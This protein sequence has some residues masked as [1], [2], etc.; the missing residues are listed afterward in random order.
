MYLKMEENMVNVHVKRAHIRLKCT[1]HVHVNTQLG[2]EK[3]RN[4]IHAGPLM[5]TLVRELVQYPIITE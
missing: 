1:L 4:W 2:R 3:Y 5:Y